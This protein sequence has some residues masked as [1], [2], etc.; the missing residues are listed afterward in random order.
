MKRI[1]LPK[2]T[3]MSP[4]RG[5]CCGT[6]ASKRFV[7]NADGGTPC[8]GLV[9]PA[10][11]IVNYNPSEGTQ[12][13]DVYTFANLECSVNLCFSVSASNPDAARTSLSLFT[14]IGGSFS[15]QLM[16]LDGTP[17]CVDFNNGD[18]F[19]F[20]AAS[21]ECNT[22]TV[23]ATNGTCG[24]NLGV[25]E[26]ISVFFDPACTICPPWDLGNR[27]SF[28]PELDHAWQLLGPNQ[29]LTISLN[30]DINEFNPS[31]S[32]MGY[33]N[34]TAPDWSSG[35]TQSA[36]IMENGNSYGNIPFT[37][38]PGEYLII[39]MT[40]YDPS[41]ADVYITFADLTCGQQISSGQINSF[42]VNKGAC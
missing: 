1:V 8:C 14:D 21:D 36:V 37:I 4:P 32:V 33:V 25:I 28:T 17:V 13:G 42:M 20:Y 35:T 31:I 10:I 29:A 6:A 23:S 3:A 22:F 18:S 41:C 40:A 9:N 5:T 27:H 24:T 19:Y 34:P 2:I 12:E 7:F 15:S 26:Q 11:S 38:A 39:R 16:P 30:A